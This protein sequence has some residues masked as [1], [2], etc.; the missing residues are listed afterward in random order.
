MPEPTTVTLDE[1]MQEFVAQAIHD[2]DGQTPE[3]I[4]RIPLNDWWDRQMMSGYSPEELRRMSEE[5]IADTRP[6]IPAEEFFRELKEHC[7]QLDAQHRAVD[8][9]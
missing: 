8:A 1:S 7:R 9:A 3:D 6:G 4:V 2:G 5:I